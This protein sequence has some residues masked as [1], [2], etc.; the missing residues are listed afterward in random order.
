VMELGQGH[1]ARGIEKRLKTIT[2]GSSLTPE[3]RAA[4]SHALSGSLF[5]LLTW[6]LNQGMKENPKEMDEMFHEM[7]WKG[8]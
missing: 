8:V 1:L 5:S 4:M 3:R 6:W 2:R 7:V